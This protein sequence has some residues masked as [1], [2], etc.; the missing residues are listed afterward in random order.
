[1][2]TYA[3][4][5]SEVRVK[6]SPDRAFTLFTANI[7]DWWPVNSNSVYKGTVSFEGDELVERSGEKVAV[8]AEVTRW[9]PPSALGL[10]WH[11]GS[12]ASRTTDILVTFTPEGDET[13]VH[14]THS[15][16]ERLLD[17]EEQSRDYAQGWP[18]VLGE[19]AKL[20]S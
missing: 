8:W 17:G 4:V 10:T 14:L 15:A 3:L 11:A 19:Y 9:D 1:M 2:T 16:W 6:A 18:P 12:D 13:V 7:G 5:E 20:F